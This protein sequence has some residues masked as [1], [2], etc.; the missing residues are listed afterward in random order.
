MEDVLIFGRKKQAVRELKKN[1][2]RAG[3]GWD[4]LGVEI[5]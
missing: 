3:E 4:G 1:L 2:G 5:G